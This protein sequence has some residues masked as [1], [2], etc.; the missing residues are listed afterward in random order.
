MALKRS[1]PKTNDTQLDLF[2]YARNDTDHADA[3]RND[4]RETL[5]RVSSENG[6]GI[7]TER[8]SAGDVV[9]SREQDSGGTLDAAPPVDKA[10]R[11]NRATGARS[12]L[13]NGEGE[14]HLSAPR[15]AVNGHQREREDPPRNQANHRI[16]EADE[17]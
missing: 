8:P 6:E 12:G 9:G 15:I 14:I 5:A 16:T 11:S 7:G 2:A 10:T 13:G 4:G 3:V 1:K 17:V